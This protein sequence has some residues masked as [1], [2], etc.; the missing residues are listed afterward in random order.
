MFTGLNF[1]FYPK[2]KLD[3]LLLFKLTVLFSILFYFAYP[4]NYFNFPPFIILF[5][6][7]LNYYALKKKICNKEIYLSLA[8]AYS[9]LLY[10][11]Y[12]PCYVYGN[13]PFLISLIFPFFLG[14]YLA[15]YPFFYFLFLKFFFKEINI[16]F[17]S[18]IAPL[19]W[20]SLE[21]IREFLFSG[22]SW[23]ELALCFSPY[24]FFIQII[25]YTGSKGISFLIIFLSILSLSDKIYHKFI[26]CLCFLAFI[27]VNFYLFNLPNNFKNTKYIK[28][29]QGNIEQDKKWDKKYQLETIDKYVKL[30]RDDDLRKID[31]IVW[32][33]TALPFYLQEVNELSSRVKSFVKQEN[34]FLVVG[35]PG[36]RFVDL[37][38]YYLYNRAYLLSPKGTILDYYEKQKL[39][40][41]GEYLPFTFLSSWFSFF[42]DGVGDFAPGE[43]TAPL[44]FQNSQVGILICYEIIFSSLVEE[45]IGKGAEVIVNI[46]NDAWFGNTS[47]PYQHLYL[48]VLRAVEQNRAVVRCTNSGISAFIS[49]KGKITKKIGLFTSGAISEKVPFIKEKTFFNKYFYYFYNLPFVILIVFFCLFF[50]RRR[51]NA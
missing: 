4:N 10:W 22:F 37:K 16:L 30:S 1:I 42:Y 44:V 25:K 32:P 51:F 18:L 24:P 29:V 19:F 31:L 39:V 23:P 41:F 7:F 3:W 50:G 28:M 20:M 13:I 49:P 48:S 21:I 46:S 9:T 15:L 5:F 11:I 27:F 36:Y 38:K 34:V 45:R 8:F 43:R 26:A 12:Y 6:L 35:A 14:L 40:P 47:G 33:E 2:N 17:L